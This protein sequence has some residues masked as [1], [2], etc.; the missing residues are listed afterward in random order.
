MN[1]GDVN[2]CFAC[3]ALAIGWCHLGHYCAEHRPTM[4]EMDAAQRAYAEANPTPAHAWSAEQCALFDAAGVPDRVRWHFGCWGLNEGD[5]PRGVC[6]LLSSS[7]WY[8]LVY[9]SRSFGLRV[10][11]LERVETGGLSLH[12]STWGAEQPERQPDYEVAI[13]AREDNDL[14]GTRLA[15]AVWQWLSVAER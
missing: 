10:W 11:R 9:T 2:L 7:H 8:E 3:D 1:P 4:E 6:N 13:D 15:C 5:I 14:M 12:P